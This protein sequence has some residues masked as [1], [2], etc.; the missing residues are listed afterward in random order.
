MKMISCHVEN[1]GKL[2][3][4][5]VDF[6][7]GVNIICEE[8]GWGKSTFA[9]FVR[10]MF[11]GLEGERKRSIAE[12]ERKRYKPWQGGVFG[13]QLVFEI[14]GQAYRISRIFHD[15]EVN[16]EFELRDAKTN[17][18]S[19]DYSRKIGEELFKINREAFMRTVFIGQSECE[20]SATDDINA[21]IGNLTD[22][23]NDLNN[24]D[25]ADKRLKEMI[26]G[27]N[28]ERVT[29][30]ISKRRE[31]I[32]KYE[33][34]VRDGQEISE[35][36]DTYQEYLHTEEEAYEALREQMQR[37]GGKQ[38]KVSK[39]QAAIAKKSEWERLKKA[40]LRKREEAEMHGKKFPGEIPSGE[41]VKRKISECSEMEKADERASFYR[42][43]EAEKS[44]FSA[45]TAVF[46]GGL[47]APSDI[48]EKIEEAGRLRRISQEYSLGQMSPE[49]K[50]R[51]GELE[52]Y[53]EDEPDS[54]ASIVGKWNIRNTKKTALPSNQA[55]LMALK[56]SMAAGKPQGM[57]K[58]SLLLLVGLLLAILGI[59]L[60]IAAA[61]VIGII[62]VV[63]GVLLLLLGVLVSVRKPAS[64]Q[65]QMS[66]EFENLKRNID[67]DAAFIAE[68]DQE[69]KDYLAAHGKI[70][71]EYAVSAML[72]E[73]T[74]EAVE[75]SSLKKKAKKAK[76]S[77]Q[78][79]EIKSLQ[80]SINAFLL[81]YGVTSTELK[82]ADDLY[83]LKDKAARYA[84]LKD[85]K[86]NF[87]RAE[88]RYRAIRDNIYAF[89]EG[90]GYEPAGN[91]FLQLN[92]I[93]EALDDYKRA[94]EALKDTE[95][96]LE[97]F[98][99]ETDI[100]MLE[101]MQAEEQLPTLEELNQTIM[102]LT[103]DMEKVHNT[104]L[105]YNKN[106]EELQEKY[107]E[108]EE[109]RIKLEELKTLQAA[110]QKKYKHILTARIKLGL[111][112]EAMTAKYADPI[113][114][115]FCK[116]Y[117]WISGESADR[118]HIDANTKVT[119]EELGKQRET[120]TL[121]T[122]YRELIGICL[123]MALVDAM[124]REE[125]PVLIMDDPFANLDD[126]KILAGR[127]FIKKIAETYQ[128]IYFTCSN[129]RR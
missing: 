76:E 117:E 127:D 104:I 125:T 34:I 78:A 17:L 103:E 19:K 114:E 52:V 29:G 47:P 122:G 79:A 74:A 10:A 94:A 69:I 14:Q 22:N 96:E 81:K 108:W 128:L 2:H 1:F 53:F 44:E 40:V 30:S 106:L 84:E 107:D 93:R 70:F 82:Y 41:E 25:A 111:A 46:N 110:E 120:D 15:K 88:S 80:Q 7:D 86:D 71:D 36:I 99:Q 101:K 83:V 92:D 56:N 39:L 67:E 42:M 119:V 109:S 126:K 16:D 27:L 116:Y 105:V 12:N 62:M 87:K 123:R 61:P 64:E 102:Q 66:P 20:T 28:P 23:S 21:K 50:A 85:K 129:S 48:D 6:S 8:N 89:L 55:A 38:K 97:R 54:V 112:K 4:Y 63:L 95:A 45:L 26:N 77:T 35:S 3:D 113:L 90:Y 49:E 5:S 115:G 13:G 91:C 37:A 60:T 75:Y 72:Q 73:I 65:E 32:N 51:L 18:P 33:R 57:K 9:A 100:S 59:I 11:Y 58:F 31:E 24:F 98:E 43:T 121:S 124:Y 118:F 68:A